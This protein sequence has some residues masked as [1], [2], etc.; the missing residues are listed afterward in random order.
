M[1]TDTRDPN[2]LVLKNVRLSYPKLFKPEPFGNEGGDPY[3]SANFILDKK[4]DAETIK[5]IKA[6]IEAV[7]KDKWKDKPTGAVK[8][9]LRDGSERDGSDGYGDGVM[10]IS[11]SSKQERRPKVVDKNYNPLSPEDGKPYAGCYVHAS[12]RLWAQDNNYGKR[13]NAE[14]RVVIHHADGEP[15]GAGAVDAE[16]DF[17]GIDLDNDSE[18][19]APKKA[20]KVGDVDLDDL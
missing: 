5:A 17:A 12:I 20:A 18:A 15:F 6:R 4:R 1:S 14:L 19:P 16:S 3:F 11:A 2:V 13:V 10:F 9:C 8:V 7:K